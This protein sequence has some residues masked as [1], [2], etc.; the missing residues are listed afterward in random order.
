[1]ARENFTTS[2]KE[3]LALRA[4]Y[5]CSFPECGVMTVGPSA[6]TADSGSRTGMACH[7]YAAAKGGSAR[8]VATAKMKLGDISNG[9]WMCYRH[10]K[11][12]DTDEDTYSAAQLQLWKKIAECRADFQHRA[13][14]DPTMKEYAD[15]GIS[16]EAA[17]IEI[18]ELDN[19]ASLIAR[20]LIENGAEQIWGRNTAHVVRDFAVEVTRNALKH[21]AASA[22]KIS[23]GS[24]GL[25]IEDDGAPF[26]VFTLKEHPNGRG[27]AA[28]LEYLTAGMKG[29]YLTARSNDGGNISEIN[30][31]ADLWPDDN[32]C[33]VKLDYENVIR[34]SEITM[35]DDCNKFYFYFSP[36]CSY[37]DIMLF[38]MAVGHLRSGTP[39]AAIFRDVS[40]GVIQFF[41]TRNPDV[42]IIVI[43]RSR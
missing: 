8:R 5:R 21:G 16:I 23:V 22:V 24:A 18:N 25:R 10:G 34:L 32:P 41:Q 40:D 2:T 26:D 20:A 27:G 17:S 7:I 12:I 43:A 37:S 35:N 15:E 33:V 9:I 42:E 1:M 28:A 39:A 11:L 6:E 38:S 19:E 36:Y 29:L 30:V 3:S 14:R 13:H 31:A 4:G